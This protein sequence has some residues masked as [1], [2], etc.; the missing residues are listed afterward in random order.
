M[1]ENLVVDVFYD[2]LYLI[3]EKL[4]PKHIKRNSTK[5]P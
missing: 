4:V 5:Q 2:K 1:P 3:V